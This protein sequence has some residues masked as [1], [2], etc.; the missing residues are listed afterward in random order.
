M[1]I[2][3]SI[4]VTIATFIAMQVIISQLIYTHLMMCF[5][6]TYNIIIKQV[7]HRSKYQEEEKKVI[8]YQI[9]EKRT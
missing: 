4:I 6:T 8:N 7:K 5:P 1:I 3:C 9:D 2:F